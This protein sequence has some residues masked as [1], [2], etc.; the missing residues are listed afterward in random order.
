MTE[1]EEIQ[2]FVVLDTNVVS[3]IYRDDPIA[4]QYSDRIVGKQAV[5]SFQTYEEL[6]HGALAR[7][8]GQARIDRMMRHVT[9]NYDVIHSSQ[10]LVGTCADLRVYCERRGRRLETA[11]AWIAA[12]AV[13]LGGSLLSHDPDFSVLKDQLDVFSFV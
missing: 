5:I 8:W 3:Y 1:I 4:R 10:R 2:P 11:D 6:M 12:T 7:N 9:A 13:M